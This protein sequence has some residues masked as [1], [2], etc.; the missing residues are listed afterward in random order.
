MPWLS[1]YEASATS[2]GGLDQKQH[3]EDT[4]GLMSREDMAV[5]MVP[6]LLG[7]CWSFLATCRVLLLQCMG[8][9]AGLVGLL[10]ALP[11]YI[12]SATAQGQ[13]VQKW[14][15]TALPL[16]RHLIECHNIYLLREWRNPNWI[17]IAG[18]GLETNWQ[19]RNRASLLL[20]DAC[21]RQKDSV[22][23]WCGFA[24]LGQRDTEDTKWPEEAQWETPGILDDW[25]VPSSRKGIHKLNWFSL[26]ETLHSRQ[27]SKAGQH[28]TGG[29]VHS[30]VHSSA[31]LEGKLALLI[32][33]EQH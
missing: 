21:C 23:C 1:L 33:G 3:T 18:P 26:V 9:T 31:V 13:Y 6:V 20:Q 15:Q 17:K 32:T 30:G 4:L 5:G 19:M 27:P 2:G 12:I 8:K 10:R 29:E 25:L 11:F 22:Q 7:H 14:L 24:K 16:A 28:P